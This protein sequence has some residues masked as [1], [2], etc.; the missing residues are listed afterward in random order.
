MEKVFDCFK[1]ENVLKFPFIMKRFVIVVKRTLPFR[2]LGMEFQRLIFIA[3]LRSMILTN[4]TISSFPK[5]LRINKLSILKH[6]ILLQIYVLI[7]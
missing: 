3:L 7:T 6:F 4:T 1:N 2:W 5:L